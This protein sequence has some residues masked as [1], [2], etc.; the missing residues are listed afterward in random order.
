MKLTT[1]QCL[2]LSVIFCIVWQGFTSILWERKHFT[3]SQNL[4]GGAYAHHRYQ[5]D[6][7]GDSII[8]FD[9]HREV[10]IAV[11]SVV[12]KSQLGTLII[13]DNH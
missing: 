13:S 1:W 12:W 5:F 2:L 7:S 11:D 6:I 4:Q 3:P 10:G 8:L 9:E